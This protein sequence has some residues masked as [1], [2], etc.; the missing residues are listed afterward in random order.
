MT[1][2]TAGESSLTIPFDSILLSDRFAIRLCPIVLQ[3]GRL[4]GHLV[5]IDYQLT[6]LAHNPENLPS[7]LS[8]RWW[9]SLNLALI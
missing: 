7:P 5:A 3:S 1:T 2:R 4:M 6:I 9:S 8:T